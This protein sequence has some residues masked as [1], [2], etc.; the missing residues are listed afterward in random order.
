MTILYIHQ[1]FC[2]DQGTGGTR[3]CDVAR[4]L[5]ETGHRVTMICGISG[6]SGFDP[7]P[8]Y[9]PFRVQWIDGIKVIICSVRY[10]NVMSVPRRMWAFFGF[11]LLATVACL[12][13]RFVDL[14]FATS[15]PLTVGIPGRLAATIKRVPFVFEVRD[16]WPEDLLAAGRLKPGLAYKAWEWLEH[17]CYAKA[18]RILLVS[19]GFHDRLL[20]RGFAPELLQTVLLGAEGAL[21][22][23][24]EPDLEYIEQHG[25]AGKTIAIFT[26]AHG[27]ANGLFQLIDAAE[28]LRDRSDISIVMIGQGKMKPALNASVAQKKLTNVFLLDPVPKAKLCG[29]LV[30]SHVGLMILKQV[31]RPR[32][33]TPNKLFDYMFAGL[34]TIVNFAGTTAEMV[35]ADGAGVASKPGCAKDLA[36]KIEYYADHPQERH[37]VGRRAREVARQ[38]YGRRM[39]A[40]QMEEVFERCL[41]E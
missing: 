36:A 26:G 16:L 34:P 30:A 15:T 28:H 27:D 18:R 9:R 11:A 23:N 25:L 1:H 12:R 6:N 7:A 37:A 19:Q 22:E 3:S 40:K 29:I 14:V 17:F 8:W 35:E 33:V 21:F 10:D 38:K 31:S 13:E 20:E 32:W 24:A 39:I 2:T 4:H 5:V 41:R